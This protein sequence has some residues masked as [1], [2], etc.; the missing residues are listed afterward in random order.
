MY[1]G[2]QVLNDGLD[3]HKKVNF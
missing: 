3:H 1:P 2:N